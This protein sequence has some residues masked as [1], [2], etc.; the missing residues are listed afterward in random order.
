MF[1]RSVLRSRYLTAFEFRQRPLERGN[2]SA[3][4][5]AMVEG[6]D[7][8]L[9]LSGT[10]SG[11][12]SQREGGGRIEIRETTVRA[13]G[14]VDDE[15]RRRSPTCSVVISSTRAWSRLVPPASTT[16]LDV[17]AERTSRL[18]LADHLGAG[19]VPSRKA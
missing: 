19:A 11:S 6:G 5:R 3:R 2:E 10:T 4:T 8:S 16:G 17:R 1:A 12:M 13:D 18:Q 7:E 9:Q 15:P 14:S